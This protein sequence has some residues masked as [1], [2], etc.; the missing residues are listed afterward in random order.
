MAEQRR[1]DV[2]LRAR[3]RAS[4][5]LAKL[6]SGFTRLAK[7]V[8]TFGVATGAA[9]AGGLAL[10]A[11]RQADVIAQ[12]QRVAQRI[13]ATTEAMSGL[14]FAARQTGVQVDEFQDAMQEMTQRVGEAAAEMQG[15]A[16]EALDRLGL[17]AERLVRL[18][19]SQQFKEIADAI[20]ELPTRGQQAFAID[21][22]F[23]G[24]AGR[25]M[26][27]LLQR[28]STGIDRLVQKARDMNA[29]FNRFDAKK[30]IEMNRAFS[31]LRSVIAAVG[32]EIAIKLSG[33][34]Q[35][36]ATEAQLL[37]GDIGKSVAN[38]FSSIITGASQMLRQVVS[39][40]KTNS[41]AIKDSLNATASFLRDLFANFPQII[42]KNVLQAVQSVL[43]AIGPTLTERSGSPL[44]TLLGAD[45]EELAQDLNEL[46]NQINTSLIETTKN[47]SEQRRQQREERRK[48]REEEAREGFESSASRIEELRESQQNA[49]LTRR[50]ELQRQIIRLRD[51][52]VRA[53]KQLQNVDKASAQQQKQQAEQQLL[54]LRGMK[55]VGEQAKSALGGLPDF[56][57]QIS[58]NAKRAAS[59]TT[60]GLFFGGGQ[61]DGA[62]QTG[63][64][65][66]ARALPGQRQLRPDVQRF[67]TRDPGQRVDP[68]TEEAK[69]QRQAQ[70][71]SNDLAEE[72]NE[73]LRDLSR[74][75]QLRV[76][77]AGLG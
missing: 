48:E 58:G 74:G 20:K 6:R 70:E 53:A 75:D 2:I 54:I 13:G 71:R 61:G 17:S 62:D 14:Q 29:T 57:R 46:N 33:P 60:L 3:D 43:N 68:A 47:L 41:G 22:I 42:K 34:L 55:Q 23:G 15:E 39:F 19:P 35:T 7:V 8:S 5:T 28:G 59:D 10:L 52:Q 44:A 4:K 69:K 66:Q 50:I 49:A 76:V 64:P 65:N 26:I 40:F 12:T 56:V 37:I 36:L 1:L 18:R 16:F 21:Q 63:G 31:R 45:P 73:L 51:R 72:R 24:D 77:A 25:R 32:R 11:K 30:V 67:L 38:L 27:N 9:A